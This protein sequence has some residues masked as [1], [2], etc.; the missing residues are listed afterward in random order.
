VREPHILTSNWAPDFVPE[1]LGDHTFLSSLSIEY[2][3]KMA[4]LAKENNFRIVVLPL[5]VDIEKKDYINSIDR[6]ELSPLD[7][8]FD[9]GSYF[10]NITY[11]EDSC[12]IDGVHLKNPQAYVDLVKRKLISPDE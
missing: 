7:S 12:F 4:T 11:L 9:F 10:E 1:K 8:I 3:N 2:L 6:S 5:P